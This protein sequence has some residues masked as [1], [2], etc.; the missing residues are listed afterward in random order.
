MTTNLDPQLNDADVELL[1]TYIDRR[2]SE[3]ERQ[4]LER[5]LE[6]EPNLRAALD[7]LRATIGLLRDLDPARPPRSFALDPAAVAPRR[8]WAFPWRSLGSAAVA[9]F[10]LVAFGA[11]LLRTVGPSG[12][13]TASAPQSAAEVAAAP[14]AAPAAAPAAARQAAEGAITNFISPTVML[15]FLTGAAVLIG[16]PGRSYLPRD[17][18]VRIADYRV[19]VTRELE[20]AE[21]KHTAVWALRA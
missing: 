3:A 9:L 21:I 4:A 7:E 8:S 16:D 14:T 5:R 15:G 12:A 2:L 20:D 18:L 17:R 13:S 10:L 1:S 11:A 19:P 6:R